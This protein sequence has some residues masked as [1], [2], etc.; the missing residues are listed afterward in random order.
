M[1]DAILSTFPR[2]TGND[3]RF[4]EFGAVMTSEFSCSS[5]I[6]TETWSGAGRSSFIL[7]GQYVGQN[8]IS[9]PV[10]Y[11]N[12]RPFFDAEIPATTAFAEVEARIRAMEAM[13]LGQFVLVPGD[14]YEYICVLTGI[15]SP[16]WIGSNACRKV[17]T[18]LATKT[19]PMEHVDFSGMYETMGGVVRCK[20][21]VP[22]TDCRLV[23]TTDI[24][25]ANDI[26]IKINDQMYGMGDSGGTQDNSP[27]VLDGIDKKITNNGENRIS[28]WEWSDFPFLVPGENRIEMSINGIA[29]L[30][31]GYI[32]YYPTFL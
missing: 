8:T 15:S 6:S 25:E 22:K 27:V 10:T 12:G 4:S 13:M 16:E 26:V 23:I 9:I 28:L 2:V 3:R 14:G 31:S 32:E 21:T 19:M 20:S 29:M 18:L 1:F 17:Y 7:T 5:S 11:S 30:P 24:R